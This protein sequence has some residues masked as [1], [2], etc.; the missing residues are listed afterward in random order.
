MRPIEIENWAIGIVERLLDGQPNEDALVELKASWPDPRKAARQ[1]AGHAN[2]ARGDRIL[3]LIGV[4]QKSGVQGANHEEVSSWYPTLSA[5]FDGIAPTLQDINVPYEGK[6][7]VAL[8]FETDRAPY[9]VK[10]PA[11]GLEAGTPVSLEVPWREGT[12][13]RTATRKDLLTILAPLA[14]VPA[15]EVLAAELFF[16]KYDQHQWYLHMDLYAIP[17]TP[18]SVVIP[19][20]K[21]HVRIHPQGL[22]APVS[23]SPIRLTPP[24]KLMPGGSPFASEPDSINVAH[25]HHDLFLQGPGRVNLS[26]E[27]SSEA[28]PRI[29]ECHSVTVTVSL[30]PVL[31]NAPALISAELHLSPTDDKNAIAHWSM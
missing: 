1:L 24:Y 21:C 17:Q 31:S 9:V 8:L 10:N 7:M 28:I 26:A 16:R 4:D 25:T 19:F 29:A 5:E 2:S 14:Q 6:T 23:I 12:A 13:T 15:F 20:H 3:W 30:S 18:A 22:P 27:T 11:F